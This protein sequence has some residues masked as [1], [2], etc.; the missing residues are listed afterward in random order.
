MQILLTN[1]DVHS[2]L[3]LEHCVWNWN[4]YTIISGGLHAAQI[5]GVALIAE[6]AAAIRGG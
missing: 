6:N 3:G 2:L 1:D 4:L 5:G